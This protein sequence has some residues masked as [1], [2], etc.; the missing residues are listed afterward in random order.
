MVIVIVGVCFG[1]RVCVRLCI[2]VG[3]G[4]VIRVA[5]VLVLSFCIRLFVT[6]IDVPR[7]GGTVRLRFAV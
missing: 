4:V 3:V 6:P 1:V 2:G 7:F 5:F